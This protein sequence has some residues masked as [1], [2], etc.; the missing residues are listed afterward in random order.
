MERPQ[1]VCRVSKKKDIT[2]PRCASFENLCRFFCDPLV[3][4]KLNFALTVAMALRPFL[5]EYQSDKPMVFFLA[6]DLE[7]L[8]RKLLTKFVKC[9]IL[10]TTGINGLLRLNVEDV[11]NHV[12]LEKVDI[13][14]ACEQIIKDSKASQKDVFQFKMECKQFLVA[15]VKKVLEK[16]P[17]KLL[18]VRSL[19]C[20]DPR[21]MC[22]KPDECLTGLRKVVD[23]LITAG[24][25]N[26]HQR[27]CALAEY[28]QLM[29]EQGHQLRLFEKGLNRLD[30]FF[31]E[32]LGTSPSYREL[33][34]VV[35]L[36]LVLSHG[37]AT[38]ERGFSVN[39]QV[40]VENLQDLSYISQRIVCDAVEKAGGI[41]NIPITKD[42]RTSV[43]AA[44]NRYSAHM[45]AQR[46]EKL[47]E[48]RQSK[49]RLVEEELESMKKKKKKLEAVI[50][51][52]T[53][54]ADHYAE[55]AEVSNDFT[56]IVKSN[57]LRK[58]AKSKVGELTDITQ[59]IQEKTQLLK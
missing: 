12:P 14:H 41:L 5:T 34:N 44:R 10:S 8:V 17:L 31:Y 3:V 20:L 47:E 6:R 32:L 54:S 57:S 59:R 11:N 33:W 38:V 13:G 50:A 40:A 45:E 46:K 15:V 27:D 23:A 22:S 29:Q 26:D 7:M 28:T 24:R 42:L 4:A 16:S 39:R 2:L 35:K 53:A 36:L 43:Q 55:K 21:L 48:C 52:L 1:D 9:S 51:D 19:S 25:V 58:T 37:Q 49:R 30:E 56:F 18:L